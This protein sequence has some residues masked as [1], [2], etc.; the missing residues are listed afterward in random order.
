MAV[1]SKLKNLY[2]LILEYQRKNA[3]SS[4]CLMNSI[5]YFDMIDQMYPGAF[6]V[7]CGILIINNAD[8]ILT[9]DNTKNVITKGDQAMIAH[10]WI[11]Q[12]DYSEVLECSSEFVDLPRDC[13]RYYTFQEFAKV[14]SDPEI[15]KTMLS[16][17]CMLNVQVAKC[18]RLPNA[19]TQYYK[20]LRNYCQ[21]LILSKKKKF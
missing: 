14:C 12:K 11:E 8:L 16:Y 9:Y 18:I 2:Q 4:E 10:V 5:F 15:V 19:Q 7:V 20:D 13:K 17:I 6:K 21:P 1:N 3:I